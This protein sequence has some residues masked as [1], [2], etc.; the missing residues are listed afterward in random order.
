MNI[1]DYA[2]A[3]NATLV[4]TRHP[5]Q[6][7]YIAKFANCNVIGV[8]VTEG[9]YGDGRTITLAINAY[10]KAIKGKVI[11]INEGGVERRLTVPK[12]E[13][14]MASDYAMR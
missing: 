12:C 7:R 3:I 2:D 14:Y 11:G 10:F 8:N 9:T 5:N 4:I 13:F 1:E 6:D